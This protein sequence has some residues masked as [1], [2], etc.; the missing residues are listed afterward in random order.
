MAKWQIGIKVKKR[1]KPY[2]DIKTLRGI[3]S[4]ILEEEGASSPLEVS[5]LITDDEEV[6]RLNQ[7][8]RGVNHTTDVLA[9]PLAA[10]SGAACKGNCKEIFILPPDATYQLGEVI[11]SYPQAQRQAEE[12]DTSV[13]EEV[14]RL[15]VHGFLHLFRYDHESPAERKRMRARER[16]ILKNLAII[17]KG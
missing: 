10:N 15:L 2:P 6:H 14:T 11:I 17:S 8:Y 12:A 1:F 9:F 3:V 13:G 7:R 16:R 4:T 5:I